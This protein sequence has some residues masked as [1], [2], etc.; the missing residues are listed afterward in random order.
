MERNKK[1]EE[2]LVLVNEAAHNEWASRVI[3]TLLIESNNGNMTMPQ[4]YET[5][6]IS[7]QRNFENTGWNV[8]FQIREKK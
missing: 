8:N 1:N 3:N 7:I 2:A 5:A 4:G 6:G